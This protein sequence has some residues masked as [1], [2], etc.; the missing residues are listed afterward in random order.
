LCEAN[1][2]S[3]TCRRMGV[4]RCPRVAHSSFRMHDGGVGALS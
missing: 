4:R 2:A 3:S 1:N